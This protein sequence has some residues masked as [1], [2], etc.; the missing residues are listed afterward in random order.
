MGV[1]ITLTLEAASGELS[2]VE[3]EGE[4]Y[5]EAKAAAEGLIP[6]RSKTIVLRTS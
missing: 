5:E 1:K 6:E 4:T 2:R 3:A